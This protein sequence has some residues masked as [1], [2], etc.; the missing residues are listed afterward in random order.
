[1]E[2]AEIERRHLHR[3]VDGADDS[4]VLTSR[5]Y[6]VRTQ[7]GGWRSGPCHVVSTTS[8]AACSKIVP[9]PAAHSAR[10]NLE[11]IVRR[12]IDAAAHSLFKVRVS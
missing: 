5:L 8:I 7:G 9:Q 12:R 2:R 11:Q 10:R 1:M 6:S 4:A 3:A